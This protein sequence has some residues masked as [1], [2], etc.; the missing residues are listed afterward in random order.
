MRILITIGYNHKYKYMTTESE[1][2]TNKMEELVFETTMNGNS[3]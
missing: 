1:E 3:I 2:L